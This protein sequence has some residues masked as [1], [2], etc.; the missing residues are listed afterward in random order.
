[1]EDLVVFIMVAVVRMCVVSAKIYQA[2]T[3]NMWTSEYVNQA[4]TEP[5]KTFSEVLKFHPVNIF[6]FLFKGEDVFVE[7]NP[8]PHAC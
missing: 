1:M 2:M 4:S 7:W 5:L 8:G 3:S 6:C